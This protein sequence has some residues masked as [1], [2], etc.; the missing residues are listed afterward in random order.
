MLCAPVLQR[1]VQGTWRQKAMVTLIDYPAPME[2]FS[3][4]GEL[5]MPFSDVVKYGIL[6]I[7]ITLLLLALGILAW[8]IY[9]FCTEKYTHT[10]TQQDAGE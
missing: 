5:R 3:K 7:S 8:Q 1:Y 6:G 10:Y 2:L 9:R 4:A